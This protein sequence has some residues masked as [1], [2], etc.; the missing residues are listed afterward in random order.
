MANLNLLPPRLDIFQFRESN[1]NQVLTVTDINGNPF[2]LTGYS[3]ELALYLQ[4]NQ[5]PAMP[6]DALTTENGRIV[7]G[8]AAGTIEL[9]NPETTVAD[10]EWVQA[11]YYLRITKNESVIPLTSGQFTVTNSPPPNAFSPNVSSLQINNTD[12]TITI[13]SGLQGPVG[14]TGPAGPTGPTGAT[15][16]TGATGNTGVQGATGPTGPQGATGATGITGATGATGAPGNTG[17]TGAT[18]PTGATGATGQTGSP[19]ATGA[20]GAMGATGST[21]PTGDSGIAAAVAPITYDAGT[22]TVGVTVGTGPNTVAAG[23]DARIVGAVQTSDL[24]SA[25]FQPTSAFD[26]AGAAAS[27]QAASDPLGSAATAQAASLQKSA[28]LFDLSNVV[29]AR[30]NLGLG[31]AAL[32]AVG[33]IAGTVAAGNDSRIVGAEQTANKGIAFG[34]APLDSNSQVPVANLPQSI[35]GGLNYQGGWDA[36]TGSPPSGSPTKGQFWIVTVAGS[37]N[38]SGITDW[39]IH[40]WAVYDGTTWDKVDNTDSVVSVFGQVGAVPDLSGDAT[41]SGSSVV[42]VTRVNGVAFSGLATGIVKNTTGTGAPSIAIAADFP[43]LNQNTTGSAANFTN[44]L[45]GDVTGTQGA[46]VVRN[47]NGV[48]LS[49]L[50]TG[51]LKNITATGAPSIAIANTDYLPVANPTSTGLLTFGTATSTTA[52]AASTPVLSLTGTPFLGTG[53][54]S[55]PLFYLNA[56]AVA[57][58]A[59][60]TNGTYIGVNAV[61]GSTSDFIQFFN[62]GNAAGFRVNT[63][64]QVTATSGNHNLSSGG[65]TLGNGGVVGFAFSSTTSGIGTADTFLTRKSAA[66]RRSGQADA[67]APV[68]QT[69][70]VQGVVAGTSNAAG[71]DRTI[72]GSQGTGTG[73]G[74]SV[75]TSIAPAGSTGSTQ[76]ALVAGTTLYSTGVFQLNVILTVATLPAASTALKGARAT[77]SDA[78]A[79]TFLGVLIGSGAVIC[80]VFC[81]GTAWVSA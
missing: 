30:T 76:N 11:Y 56:G 50:A 16:T 58:T 20:T 29:T 37:T 6:V 1:L 31:A 8:G 40:D 57:P 24:G 22:K 38:L 78:T 55:V 13:L 36:S 49:G 44:A 59:W 69:D 41:T 7:L 17:N 67:A 64:G 10:Y 62:N 4:T 71:A 39:K 73:A 28:N 9:L 14:S 5:V 45:A 23:N 61:S 15:G 80:P 33:I 25:A 72:A 43:T 32:L 54:T 21:G 18:G 65:L 79:P 81:N 2:D 75:I 42:A 35:Q 48:V 74:G 77:V 26:P 68:A 63:A 52:G 27:A 46:T 3:A 53:T 70:S 51:L 19:G 60:S 34:Y 47:I 66:N 12:L